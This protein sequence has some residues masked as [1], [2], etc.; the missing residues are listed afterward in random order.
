[1]TN[2]IIKYI[3]IGL[4]TILSIRY[5]PSHALLDEE[6]LIVA[7]IVSIGYALLDKLIPSYTLKS[8]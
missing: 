5:I 6:I 1:M 7:F 2:R 3:L 8:S 4:L